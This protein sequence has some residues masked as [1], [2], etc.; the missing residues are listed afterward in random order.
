MD[1]RPL[2]R[3]QNPS[4]QARYAGYMAR[5][6]CYFLRIIA[7]KI[8]RGARQFRRKSN[9]SIDNKDRLSEALYNAKSD[10]SDDETRSDAESN[11]DSNSRS[12]LD[13]F[14]CTQRDIDYMKDAQALFRMNGEQKVCA[15]HLWNVLSSDEKDQRVQEDQMEALLTALSKF[16]FDTTNNKPFNSGLYH[17]LAVLGISNNTGRPRL[18]PAKTY[19][20][21]LAERETGKRLGVKLHTLDYQHTAVGIGQ[22]VVGKTFS[23]GYKDD[24]GEVEEPEVDNNGE[25][26]LK[27]QNAQST[28]T[29]VGTYSVP[30]N[31]IKHLS[32]R[33]IDAFR[34]LSTIS[35]KTAEL[36]VVQGEKRAGTVDKHSNAWRHNIGLVLRERWGSASS[37]RAESLKKAMQQVLGQEEVNFRSFEQEQAVNAVLDRQTPLVVVLPTGGS[38][39][40]LFMLP[41]L[42]EEG[43]VTVVVVLY[44]QLITSTVERI[45]ARSINCIEWRRGNTDLASIVVVSAD[46]AGDITSKGNFLSYAQLLSSKGLLRRV[47]S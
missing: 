21:M 46:K 45:Q 9:T 16:I 26:L 39:S 35:N 3:L 43:G 38:K 27:L 14:T 30:I 28:A 19:A 4:S 13:A 42:V 41:A 20:Y 10:M 31:I 6:V 18:R 5:F 23:K 37:K 25:D 15:A 40:L 1:L 34:P 36:S 8:A 24:V 12:T 47:V 22:V 11:S 7:N 17:F 32:V 44:Q 29:G 2:A 33:S